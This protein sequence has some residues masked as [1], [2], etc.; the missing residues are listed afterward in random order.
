LKMR[1]EVQA[2]ALTAEEALFLVAVAEERPRW[3]IVGWCAAL[4]LNTGLRG[5]ELKQLTLGAIEENPPAL[6][7]RRGT[8]KTDAGA[9]RVPLNAMAWAALEQLRARAQRLGA[10]E[11]L[12]YLLP[13]NMGRHTALKDPL[14]GRTGYDPTRPQKSLRAAW[15]HVCAA[16]GKRWKSEHHCD[17]FT[18]LRFHD[19][20]HTF[21]TQCGQAGVPIER[22][23]A[24]VG[25]VSPVMTRYYMH[26][27]DV[28][29]RSV[30]NTVQ[31]QLEGGTH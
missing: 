19:L 11:P 8:T 18:D 15:E 17:P 31:L 25:H 7:V 20:R 27:N 21:V 10:S 16:A 29:M 3:N 14:C 1:A 6:W 26:L 5:G 23:M 12:H 9:R 4:V 30:V 22:V 2:R 28:T 24:C 13:E